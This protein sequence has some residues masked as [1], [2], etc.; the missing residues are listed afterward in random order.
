[1]FSGE[2]VQMKFRTLKKIL[3]QNDIMANFGDESLYFVG[4]NTG[5]QLLGE[6]WDCKISSKDIKKYVKEHK[7]YKWIE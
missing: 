1:M 3:K 6:G 5:F 2:N 7:F 4:W